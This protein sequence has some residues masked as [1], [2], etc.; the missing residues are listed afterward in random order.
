MAKD[1][2]FNIHLNIDGKD[3]VVS[4]TTSAEEMQKA[5]EGAKDSTSKL[6]DKLISLN[7]SIDVLRNLTGAVSQF[8]SVLNSATADAQSFSQAMAAANTMAGKDAAGFAQLKDEVAELSKTIPVARDQLA[9]G[10]YQVISNGVPEDNWVSFLEKS[11]KSSVG[12]LANLEEV[13]KVTSTV[14]KN[15]GLE[16]SA[17]QE[18]QDKIQLTAKNGVTSFEQ[19]AQALPRVTGN[20]STLGVTIDELMA[21]FSTLTGVS[22]NTAE[23]STQLAAVFTA[24][25]KP[26]SEATEMAQKMG[27]QFDAASI[28]AAGGLRQFLTQ[29]DAAV[30]QYSKSHK[31]LS[32]EVY[33]RLFG[34]AESLRA[35]GPL[36]GNLADT[37]AKNVDNMRDSS[38]TI[39][40]AFETVAET[41][42]SKSQLLANKLGTI[43]DA[44]Y[45][46]VGPALPLLNMS[47]QIGETITSVGVLVLSLKGLGITSAMSGLLGW[48]RM[49]S[50]ALKILT[51]TSLT[52]RA[53]FTTLRVATI[54]LYGAMSL[55]LTL[56]ISGVIE[57]LSHLIGKSEE[58]ADAT[59]DLSRSTE[60]LK[61][62]EDAYKQA[63]ANARVDMD[64]EIRKL[65]ELIKGKGDAKAAVDG[66]NR[67]YGD[68][69]GSHKTAA[70]W[71][72]VLTKKSQ[73]YCEQ[74]GY[75]AQMKALAAEGAKLD[76]DLQRNFDQRRDLWKNGGAQELISTELGGQK[77]Y[78]DSKELKD[79]RKE[80]ARI[81][82]Q[83]KEIAKRQE[84]VNQRL[85]EGR[86]KLGADVSV[87]T[88]TPVAT[89]PKG[90]NRANGNDETLKAG[91][92]SY[93]DLA[94]N[95][96]IWKKQLDAADPSNETLTQGLIRQIAAAEEAQEKIRAY[97][98]EQKRLL[99][100]EGLKPASQPGIGIDL[101]GFASESALKGMGKDVEE[102]GKQ[103]G[104]LGQ[105]ESML[106]RLRTLRQDMTG[107][108]LKNA[109]KRIKALES[110]ADSLREYGVLVASTAEAHDTLGDV[111]KVVGALQGLGQSMNGLA[112]D[113]KALGAAM[114][115]LSMAAAVAQLVATMTTKLSESFTIWDF[116]AGTIA[117]TAA[118]VS[119]ASQLKGI[120][121]AN[122]GI[123]SGPTLGLIG[124]YSGARSNPE[125]VAPLDKL[126]SMIGPSQVSLPPGSIVG[127][128]Q[129]NDILLVASHS[130]NLKKKSGRRYGLG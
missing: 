16:W 107:E 55:G 26:S 19:L 54:A 14:I 99:N 8:C 10:L 46:K 73:A 9:N 56:A 61:E 24:L 124:E 104:T 126:R 50:V 127:K 69:F 11:A 30:E 53:G 64:E 125:V 75:E 100:M 2:N 130:S 117:G 70:A 25:V 27:I 95:I 32:E 121:F 122:G 74:L 119:A 48:T 44:I 94:H 39:E 88:V 47:S 108:D 102:A 105:I 36:T 57:L 85:D 20:A 101:T 33:G 115:G 110:E 63:A 78:G 123:V 4:V 90:A 98:E 96:G 58:A 118:V 65:G 109:N 66:L 29:L 43:S 13:V 92:K 59:G 89:T 112:G 1:I 111:G 31:V 79:L 71:Y 60:A 52:T 17:A 40:E 21:T 37:F 3:K 49:E 23:V 91:A 34:S 82:A 68:V 114:A 103:I 83:Q 113:S 84:I 93:S 67:K 72:D 6:R 77:H 22:G 18:I 15:Y 129:G 35:L 128:V 51:A 81:I 38:G 41:G 42:A 80:G 116:I 87:P 45:E 7:G 97:Q 106:E 12:G 62:S 86:K 5:I 28:K 76:I 120:A